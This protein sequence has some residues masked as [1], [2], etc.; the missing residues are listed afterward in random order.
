MRSHAKAP[1]AG[2]VWIG[3]AIALAAALLAFAIAASSAF[4]TV[5]TVNTEGASAE[6]DSATLNGSYVSADGKEAHYFFEWGPTEAYG[7]TTPLPPGAVAG[8]ETGF[9]TVPPVQISGLLADTTY[10]YRLV[11]SDAD[12]VVNGS[13]S[14]LT[15]APA[16]TNLTADPASAI[17]GDSAALNASFDADSHETSYFFEWGPGT[18]YGNKAPLPPGNSVPAGS[19]RVSVPPVAISGLKPGL[20][21]HYRVVASNATGTTTSADAAFRTA[22]APVVSG[23]RSRNLQATSADI[24]GEINPRLAPT[25]YRFEWGPTASYGNVTPV[26]DGALGSGNEPTT[27]SA[28]LEGLSPGVTYHFRLVASNQ[29]GTTTSVDQT[30]GFYPANCPNAQLRQETR[31]DQLP[32][33]RAY[34]LVTPSFAQGAIVFPLG[35]PVAPL[36]TSPSRV[37]FTT[38]AGLLPEETGGDPANV[39][40]DLYVAARSDTGWHQRYVGRNVT[41]T[42]MVGGPPR[43]QMEGFLQGTIGPQSSQRGV[44]G[45]PFLTQIA[46]YDRGYPEAK[47]YGVASNAPYVW[48]TTTGSQIDRWPTNLAGTPGGEGFVGVPEVSADFSHF[49]FQS[50]VIFA[51]GGSHVERSIVCCPPGLAKVPPASIYD[52]DL[53]TRRVTLASVK[54]G[55]EPFEGNV[56]AISEDGSRILMAEETPDPAGTRLPPGAHALNDVK[57]PFYLRIDGERTAEIAPGHQV[58]FVGSTADGKTVYLRSKEQLTLDDHDSSTDLYVWHESD[59]QLTR[60]SVGDSGNAGNTDECGGITWNGGGCNVEVID[61]LSYSGIWN[62]KAEEGFQAGQGGDGYSDSTIASKNGDIYFISPEQL[63]E[64]KGEADQANLYLFRNGT[65]RFVAALDPQPVCSSGKITDGC[66]LGPIARLQVTPNGD[67]M[68]FVA[69]ANVTGY[70]S[71]GHTEMYSY[72]PA[73]GRITCASCR[74]DG[75]A[76]TGEV[77]GSQKGLFQTYDGRVFFSSPDPLVPRDTDGVQDVYEFTEGRPRLI[78]AGLGTGLPSFNGFEG[79]LTEP[80][81]VTVSANGTDVY[82]ATIDTLVTQDHNGA[83]LKIYDARTGGG[84]PAERTPAKCTAADEC[85]GSGAIQP[86][87]PPDRTS[88]GFGTPAKPKAHKAKKHQKKKAHKKKH[89]HKRTGKKAKARKAGGEQGRGNR[90]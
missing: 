48:D 49:V 36:A 31:S 34:E 61:F 62:G 33:C 63:I 22:E 42:L 69:A 71:A 56:L 23:L 19:G 57:G 52:N 8:T 38:G 47:Q 5:E 32:D 43:N 75:I 67:H 11:V 59:E 81:L 60:V 76:P 13:D 1:S 37:S 66:A 39:D 50:N 70:N 83:A 88:A 74:L 65:L 54:T 26:P 53:K 78:S 72:D 28:H 17:K 89:K 24:E 7:E 44:Q 79:Y 85:H 41:E 40:G 35:G 12:A 82:F 9:Q 80:G 14:T 84:F 2:S 90:G 29:Y 15:T 6:K 73:S 20:T 21:Y 64:G 77:L 45:D 3:G 18:A 58:T 10:H 55:G 46:D 27:V 4:A 16:V 68:A 86:P 87:L 25:T 51:D 30:L